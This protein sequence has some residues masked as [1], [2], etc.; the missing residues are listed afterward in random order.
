MILSAW[1]CIWA[2]NRCTFISFN[3]Y[4]NDYVV[5]NEHIPSDGYNIYTLYDLLHIDLRPGQA[6]KIGNAPV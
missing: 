4:V 3:T 6:V 2:Y 1:I 5:I